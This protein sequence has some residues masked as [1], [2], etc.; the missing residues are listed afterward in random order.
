MT[1]PKIFE[2]ETNDG[3]LIKIEVDENLETKKSGST[4][5]VSS[6]STL[7]RAAMSFGS[8]SDEIKKVANNLYQSI[9]D[10]DFSPDTMEVEFGLK[11]GGEA[12]VFIAKTS[13]EANFKV[14][15]KWEKKEKK[16]GE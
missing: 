3:S 15:L 2:L 8:T 5:F 13:L 1:N 7:K 10:A 12:G 6:S 14:K 9:K 11:V 16:Q 4:E